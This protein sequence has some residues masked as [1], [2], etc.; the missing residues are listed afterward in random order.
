MSLFV[1]KQVGQKRNE[2]L[3]DTLLATKFRRLKH[4]LCIYVKE[5]HIEKY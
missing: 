2:K 1:L 5:G 4:K 3:N